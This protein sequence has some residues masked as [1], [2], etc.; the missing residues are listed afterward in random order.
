M[1]RDKRLIR[2]QGEPLIRRTY[3]SARNMSEEVWVLIAQGADR[4]VI[5]PWLDADARYLADPVPGAGPLGA[6]AGALPRISGEYALLLAVDY[7]LM[8]GAFLRALRE[9][10]SGRTREAD[11]LV[12]LRR[13]I[14][15]VA[16]AFY[17]AA[18]A[19]SLQEAFQR[20]ER[21]LLRWLR[22][23]DRNVVYVPEREWENWGHGDVFHNMNTPEDLKQL[24][25]RDR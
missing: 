5:A 3:R 21:S 19:G 22:G 14:P 17:R 4:D 18:L 12:P 1:G 13:E 15:Q 2:F 25:P 20:G 9:N 24:E 23:S 7:P 16:C 11:V 10:L 8:T 6:L